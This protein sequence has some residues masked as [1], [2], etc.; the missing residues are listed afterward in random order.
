MGFVFCIVFV[1]NN[2]SSA[3]TSLHPAFATQ[4]NLRDDYHHPARR[5]RRLTT[6]LYHGDDVLHFPHRTWRSLEVAIATPPCRR[7]TCTTP[8]LWNGSH[9]LPSLQIFSTWL[10]CK[11]AS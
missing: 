3:T 6:V 7:A 8:Q 4:P 1:F 5:L 10:R 2:G 11:T 9:H